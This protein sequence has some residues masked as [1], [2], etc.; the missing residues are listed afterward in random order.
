MAKKK[1]PVHRKRSGPRR[2]LLKMEV[3]EKLAKDPREE[4]VHAASEEMPKNQ[5]N[6]HSG[7]DPD[8]G[9]AFV[10]PQKGPLARIK[11]TNVFGASEQYGQDEDG[12]SVMER[13]H[14][15]EV[16][17]ESV[18]IQKEIRE[19]LLPDQLSSLHTGS[20]HPEDD[21]VCKGGP[22][23]LCHLPAFHFS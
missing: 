13:M 2:P 12:P 17:E 3:V 20:S 19:P 5:P 4:Q 9:D 8:S 6:E 21:R 22:M 11:E 23:C 14:G 18:V 7:I 1:S 10:G 15:S 16:E